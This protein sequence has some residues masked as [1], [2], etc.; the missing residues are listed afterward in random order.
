VKS[1]KTNSSY[2]L[3]EHPMK[4]HHWKRHHREGEEEV[5]LLVEAA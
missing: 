5:L 1:W 3:K 2:H 4:Y